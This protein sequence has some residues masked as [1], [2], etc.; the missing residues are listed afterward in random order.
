MIHATDPTRRC[1]RA[2]AGAVPALAAAAVRGDRRAIGSLRPGD[3]L[4]R[5]AH[6]RRPRPASG[7]PVLRARSDSSTTPSRWVLAACRSASGSA[8][9]RDADALREPRRGRVDVPGG[10]RLAAPRPG[11]PRAVRGRDPHRQAGRCDGRADGDALGAAVRDV[12]H[13]RRVPAVRRVVGALAETG[14]ARRRAARHPAGRR[15]PQ[16]LAGRRAARHPETSSAT[17]TSASASTPATASRF[18]KTRWRW[19]RRSPPGVHD[20]LQGHGASRNTARVSCSPRSRSARASSTC[21]ASSGS[22][23]AARPE[24]RFN[25]EMITRDPLKVPCLDRAA[26]G[27]PSPTCRADSFARALCLVRDHPGS[28]R[29]PHISP[30]PIEERLRIEEENVR[31]SLAFARDCLGL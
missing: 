17:T 24:I 14:R 27:R 2:C 8:T 25:L 30:L 3:P 13:R 21:P 18:W 10:D 23:R 12:R 29:L 9:T 6:G 11:R 26:T 4:V 19:S 16:G 15:E 28:E 22:L 20:P 5:R 1:S 31:L 7:R